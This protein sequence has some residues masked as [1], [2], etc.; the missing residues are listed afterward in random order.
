MEFCQVAAVAVAEPASSWRLGD[1]PKRAYELVHVIAVAHVSLITVYGFIST[2][3]QWF[4]MGCSAP[5]QTTSFSQ[6]VDDIIDT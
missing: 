3:K 2:Y 1:L 4:S 6:A 5:W